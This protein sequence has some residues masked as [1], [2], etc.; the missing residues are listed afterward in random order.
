M[1][2]ALISFS[3]GLDGSSRQFVGSCLR[4]QQ[5]VGEGNGAGVSGL[6]VNHRETALGAGAWSV[7]QFE[8]WELTHLYV[9]HVLCVHHITYRYALSFLGLRGSTKGDLHLRL[10]FAQ[11]YVQSTKLEVDYANKCYYK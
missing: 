10:G 3:V 6:A 5:G 1:L 2:I 11:F 8:S 4:S 7:E 9:V